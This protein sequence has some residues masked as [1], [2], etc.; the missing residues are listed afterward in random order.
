MEEELT[1]LDNITP[2]VML[3]NAEI[4]MGSYGMV[5]SEA[6]DPELLRLGK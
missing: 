6:N 5:C 3:E 2:S 4:G 1:A